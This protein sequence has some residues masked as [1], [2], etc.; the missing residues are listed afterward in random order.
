MSSAATETRA[1]GLNDSLSALPVQW[2]RIHHVRR[3]WLLSRYNTLRRA[4]P[5]PLPRPLPSPPSSPISGGSQG[6]P[7]RGLPDDGHTRPPPQPLI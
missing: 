1:N 7:T 4:G 3:T 6:S 2:R 5:Y